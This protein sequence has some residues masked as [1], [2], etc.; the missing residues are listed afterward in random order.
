M[1]RGRPLSTLGCS[2]APVGRATPAALDAQADLCLADPAVCLVLEAADG[3]VVVLNAQRQILAANPA[4]LEV[5]GP[6][7]AAM[8]RGRRLGEAL[9]CVNAMGGPDGCGSSRACAQC[10]ALEAM[11]A[12][13]A[14]GEPSKGECLLSL[15]R[16]GRWE[17]REF[18]VRC[19][20]VTV[21]GERLSLLTLQDIS[22]R[23]RTE[24][25]E[26]IFIDGLME[27]LQ[28]LKGWRE[29]LERAGADPSTLA[30][31]LLGLAD[32]LT[33]EVE[34][35]HLLLQ[36]ERGELTPER[37]PVPP[38]R[39]LEDL[40]ASL[41]AETEARLVCLPP[42]PGGAPLRTDPA[43]LRRVLANMVANA[44]EAI[45]PGAQ[46]R[47]WFEVRSGRPAFVVKNP[48]CMPPEVA[49]RVF[50]R[51]FSTK[52][53]RGRGAGTYAMKVLGETI[54]GGKV[55]FTTSWDQ[56][57]QFFIELPADA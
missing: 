3:Y 20:P 6:E 42:P 24:S 44:L 51:S 12:N 19:L 50:Q 55:G 14:T 26:R 29:V 43:I 57:T 52:A 48:G 4:L 33:A 46:A 17:A 16:E 15:R 53:A 11:L 5:L 7:D 34:A 21:A 9:F 18:A 27:T 25:L 56:G 23:K 35:Q 22:A 47:I 36:A 10:G 38:E 2:P 30:D 45:P 41:G 28:G 31:Q 32:Q 49:D 54:L 40:V 39:L 37:Q 13:L 8:C 1:R